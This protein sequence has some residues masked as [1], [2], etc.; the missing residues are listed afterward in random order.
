MD[1]LAS[2]ADFPDDAGAIPTL[3]GNFPSFWSKNA[4]PSGKLPE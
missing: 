4:Y 1:D 2:G 3:R